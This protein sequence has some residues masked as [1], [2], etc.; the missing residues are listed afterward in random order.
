MISEIIKFENIGTPNYLIKLSHLVNTDDYTD[1][2]VKDFFIN[3]LIDNNSIFD[4]GVYLLNQI[5][6]LAVSNNGILTISDKYQ[7][8]FRNDKLLVNKIVSLFIDKL[9][10]DEVFDKIFNHNTV[11]H[12]VDLSIVIDN[13]AFQFKYSKLKQFLIDFE[14]MD[15][16]PF[17]EQC[18]CVCNKYKKIFDKKI[19]L[20]IKRQ[21]LSLKEFNRLQDLKNKHGEEAEI[22]ILNIEKQ[23]FY[24]H[25]LIDAIEQISHID[26]S[27]GYDVAS[28]QCD[29]STTIDKLIEVKSYSG[30]PY[31]YWSQNE[32]RV[33]QEEQDNYFLYLVNRD[34]IN[35]HDYQPLIIQNPYKNVANSSDWKKD[36]Q[37]WLFKMQ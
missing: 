2:S 32:I 30:E 13:N 29:S 7:H 36:C 6:F 35:N 34:E 16:H 28:L 15:V 1:D 14:I 10:S 12:D 31:F 24:N 8:F 25:A 19:I 23:K 4:G 27:A 22:F 33:A 17:K 3:K 37:K 21:K 18:F 20:K 11:Y 5:D 26:A 9:I